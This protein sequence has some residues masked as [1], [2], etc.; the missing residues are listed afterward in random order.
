MGNKLTCCLKPN[1]NPKLGQCSRR[2][3]PN[4]KSEV[5]EAA[6][7]DTMAVVTM[8]ASLEPSRFSFGVS[9]GHQL[10]HISD[11]E[12][13][14]GKKQQMSSALWCTSGLCCPQGPLGGSHC[15]GLLPAWSQYS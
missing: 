7:R 2:V 10:E 14:E 6:A 1:A 12:M 4:C 15:L 3:K 13:P 8:P 11:L 5:Y 9:E